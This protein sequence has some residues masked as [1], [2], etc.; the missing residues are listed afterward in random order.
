MLED[1]LKWIEYNEIE[2]IYTYSSNSFDEKIL[3]ANI[4]QFIT[5][6]RKNQTTNKEKLIVLKKMKK[7]PVFFNVYHELY[8]KICL[9]SYRLE[10][11]FYYFFKRKKR[12]TEYLCGQLGTHMIIRSKNKYTFQEC[13]YCKTIIQEVL[14][15]N[16]EDVVLL[17]QFMD[18]ISEEQ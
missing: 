7:E 15:K 12:T 10:S 3:N 2:I 18:Y 9:P 14:E 5:D 13:K 11:I 17:G 16:K 6:T 4:E 8:K 1:F